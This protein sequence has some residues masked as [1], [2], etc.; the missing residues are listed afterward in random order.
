MISCATKPSIDAAKPGPMLDAV[1]RFVLRD[2]PELV[3]ASAGVETLLGF[4]SDQF[5]E[6]KVRLEDRIHRDDAGVAALLFSKEIE[7]PTGIFNIRMRHADG[8]I[9][10]V[11][12]RYCKIQDGANRDML[13]DLLLE[14]A[15]QV[16]EPGDATLI[17]SFK[18]LIEQSTD[19]I[20]IK[21]RNHV[22]LAASQS[23][24]NLTESAMELTELAGKT[25]Y[26]LHPE[27]EADN[28]YLLE[29]QAFAA[30]E[31][32]NQIQQVTAQDGTRHWI[33]NRKYPINGP[34]GGFIGIFGVAPE[35]THYI[36][37][38][39]RLIESEE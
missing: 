34:D 24:P 11:K 35:I 12:G 16:R 38:Q 21:N 17:A 32:V 33:D 31:R 36:E 29:E 15:R 19:Y 26:D 25:D 5:L 27:E 2:P 37:T 30:G 1:F 20:Y 4:T 14:D 6:S 39:S 23:L 22:I 9:R 8:R 10:C 13:L 7:D 18:S 3:S 28:Y